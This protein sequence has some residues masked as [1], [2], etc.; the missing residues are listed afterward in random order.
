MLIDVIMEELL[1]YQFFPVL[2]IQII[3]SGPNS[4]C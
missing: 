3:V 1:E 4:I 2:V